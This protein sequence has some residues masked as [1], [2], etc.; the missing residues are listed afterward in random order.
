MIITLARNEELTIS[1]ILKESVKFSDVLV[2]ND[3]SEDNT[4]NLIKK[5]PVKVITN[6]KPQ[7]YSNSQRIGLKYALKK[8]ITM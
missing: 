5:F 4:L 8:N 7:G 3:A 6:K 2:V 1:K